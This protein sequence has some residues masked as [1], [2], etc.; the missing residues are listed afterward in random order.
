M[1]KNVK[2]SPHQADDPRDPNANGDLHGIGGVLH[3]PS[4]ISDNDWALL[5]H[6]RGAVRYNCHV[7]RAMMAM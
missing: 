7:R 4:R 6:A 1:E 2:F 5:L 3:A